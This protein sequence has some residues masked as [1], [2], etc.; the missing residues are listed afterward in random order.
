[1]IGFFRK[2]AKVRLSEAPKT[3][4]SQPVLASLGGDGAMRVTTVYACVRV[5]AESIGMLPLKMYRVTGGR[6]SPETKH[7][8]YRVLA[9]KPNSFQTPIEF[10]EYAVKSLCLNG[11][12]Y[13]LIV[14]NA[15]GQTTELLPMAPDAVSVTMKDDY[16]LEYLV[17]TLNRRTYALEQPRVFHVRLLSQGD[18]LKGMS[19]IA[20]ARGLLETDS[21]TQS[22]A[23][24]LFTNGVVASG[25]I[26]LPDLLDEE[27]F[28]NFKQSLTESYVGFQNSNKPLILEG[29]AKWSNISMSNSDSQFL[30]TRKFNREEIAKIFRV[31]PHL[32][33]DLEHATFSNIEHQ[34]MEFVQYTLL[35]Y[36]RKIEQRV[37]ADLLPPEEQAKYYVKFNA[38]ALLRGDILT[39]YNSY[40]VAINTGFMSVNEAREKEDLSPV[41]GGEIY[42][43]PLDHGYLGADGRV[44]NPNRQEDKA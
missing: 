43:V 40:S 8:L 42:R 39:R 14:R 19:P 35:P 31:P 24:N 16:S 9:V 23:R 25:V 2:K 37:T 13:A 30:E 12:F 5:L 27:S 10:W 21:A 41:K 20:Y 4:A 36:L 26:E 28:E 38:D 32:I 33:G 11:N 17:T 7:P 1:M 44:V 15:L 3:A 29:G 34:S 18:C 22:H 6:V